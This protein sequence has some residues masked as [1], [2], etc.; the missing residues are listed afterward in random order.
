[1]FRADTGRNNPKREWMEIL[2]A[3]SLVV[4]LMIIGFGLSEEINPDSV[5]NSIRLVM[6]G[7]YF[8]LGAVYLQARKE[9]GSLREEM[10][11]LREDLK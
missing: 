3:V 8:L 4:G 6:G 10:K 1:M 2:P 11:R 9:M 5:T 7:V